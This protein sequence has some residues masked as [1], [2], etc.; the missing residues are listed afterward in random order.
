MGKISDIYFQIRIEYEEIRESRSYYHFAFFFFFQNLKLEI[1]IEII[2][3]ISVC[4]N[5]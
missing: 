3:G 4:F 2:M 1:S 5:T